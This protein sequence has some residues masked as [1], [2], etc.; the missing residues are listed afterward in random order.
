MSTLVNSKST[1][2]PVEDRQASEP[3]EQPP[4]RRGLLRGA[5]GWMLAAPSLFL[6]A[7]LF[8][9][10]MVMLF[11]NSFHVVRFGQ[12]DQTGSI[13]TWAEFLTSGY[14]WGGVLETLR[15]A[16]LST[17]IAVAVGV[18]TAY[19]LHKIKSVPWRYVGLFIVFAPLMTS[20][21]ARTYGWS[22]LLDDHGLLNSMLTSVGLPALQLLYAR[23]SVV[24][25]LV[26]IFLP[27]I[28]FP[29]MS[30]LGQLDG[31]V[32][33]AAG[34]LGASRITTFRRVTLPLI[35]PGIIGG[36]QIVFAMSM[37]SF[38]TPSLLGG[39]RVAVLA[40][41]VYSDVNNVQWPMASVTSF[42]LLVLAL[43]VLGLFTAAQKKFSFGGQLGVTGLGD[44]KGLRIG[45]KVWLTA[46][47]IFVLSPLFII[48]V[49]SFSSASYGAWPIPGW[50]MKWYQNLMTQDGLAEATYASLYIAV[51]STAIVMV[52]GTMA[53]L[54]FHRYSSKVMNGAQVFSLAPMVVPKVT[55][56][57]GAFLLLNT[58]GAFQGITGVILMHV[59]IMLPFVVIVLTAALART[60]A[61]L[62][63]AA[64]DLGANPWMAFR[65]STLF[66]IKPSLI[67]ATIFAFIISFDE[68]DMTVFLLRPGQETLPV[69]MFVYM[70]KYQDPTLAALA[71]I[72]I[73]L[74]LVLAAVAALFLFKGTR[75]PARP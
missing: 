17:V 11:E 68:V 21:V 69:W 39:G 75:K 2:D 34:D 3:H 25:A 8:L 15:I 58:V 26:H 28:V 67:A 46:I 42:V 27:F 6:L 74:S 55:I 60:D 33:D 40:T 66:A 23:P 31:A 38:A 51:W 4:R 1:H 30:S 57:L 35:A 24:I 52:V 73:S 59:I 20:V 16:S 32:A 50:S 9:G 63:E 43:V 65:A 36:A 47:Y 61:T 64:R 12:P 48:V 13:G 19:G 45:M 29:V 53:S 54:A 7:T 70:Q 5:S 44:T 62:D 37:S 41:M 14:R 71:T 10:A 49:S 72:L 22:L 18:P 56:G